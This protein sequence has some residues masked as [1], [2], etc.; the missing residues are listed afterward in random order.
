LNS[1]KHIKFQANR[2]ENYPIRDITGTIDH[3]THSYYGIYAGYF[4]HLSPI[5]RPGTVVGFGWDCKEK[6]IDKT[7]IGYTD[8]KF[9]PYFGLD[10]HSWFFSFRLS[11]E[12]IGAGIN[13]LFG[14]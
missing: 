5:F 13:V 1:A 4:L 8:Y 7:P 11:N 10:I 3:K 6:F 2:K 9:S 12:G 14:R